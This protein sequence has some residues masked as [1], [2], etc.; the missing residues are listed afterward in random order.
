MALVA[1]AVLPA[2]GQELP[3]AADSTA[4]SVVVGTPETPARKSKWKAAALS[5]LVP[6]LGEAYAG[7]HKRAR[8]FL[9][10]EG[11]MWAGFAA[12]RIY[13]GWRADDYRVYAADHAAVTLNGQP[14]TFFRD[15]GA[16]SS[17]ELFNFQQ[18]L[19]LGSRVKQY[20]GP[21]AWAWDADPSRKTYLTIR[22]SSRRAYTRSVY[23]I[24]VALTTR[25]IS[26]IDASKAVDAGDSSSASSS[27]FRLNLSP[28]G[29][30]W[31]MAGLRF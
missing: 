28:D 30:L 25:L 14:D 8:V 5:L 1:A 13:G 15:I 6:G 29:S 24:G 31:L 3:A 26:A 16:F 27:P 10:T 11:I 23:V 20:T 22:R 12:F 19:L 7:A 18:Q 17:S 4:I 2:S 21:D 9:I